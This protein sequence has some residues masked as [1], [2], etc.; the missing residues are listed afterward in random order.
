[1]LPQDETQRHVT[2]GHA[3]RKHQ[4]GVTGR[5][6]WQARRETHDVYIAATPR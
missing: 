2:G 5:C 4:A 1:M 6:A 3:L